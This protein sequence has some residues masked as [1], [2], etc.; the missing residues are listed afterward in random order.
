MPI[1]TGNKSI[2]NLNIV[3]I[4]SNNVIKIGAKL[5]ISVRKSERTLEK[6]AFFNR[7]GQRK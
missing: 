7:V 1:A 5:Y 3:F 6:F 4:N 2:S